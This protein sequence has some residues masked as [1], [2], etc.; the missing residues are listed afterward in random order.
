MHT[1]VANAADYRAFLHFE[2]DD[3]PVWALRRIFHAQLHVLEELRVPQRL[4]IAAQRVFVVRIAF[5]AKNAGLQR[6]GANTT[7]ANEFD[8]LNDVLLLGR[9]LLR[10]RG[11]GRSLS[12]IFYGFLAA[13]QIAGGGEKNRLGRHQSRRIAGLGSGRSTRKK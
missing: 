13:E 1:V 5:T 8:A 3:F 12:V 11:L 9:L 10:L 2:N 4:E 6:V 7:V